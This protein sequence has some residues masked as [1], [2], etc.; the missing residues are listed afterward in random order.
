MRDAYL[1]NYEKYL[2]S[3]EIY[4]KASGIVISRKDEAEEG[5]YSH[6]RRRITIDPDLPPAMEIAVLLHELGHAIDMA[7]IK[8]PKMKV[9][10]NIYYDFDRGTKSSKK[11]SVVLDMEKRAWY[12]GRAIAKM[13]RI[14]LGKWYD[15]TQQSCLYSYRNYR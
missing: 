11:R 7:S 6:T 1:K 15:S 14:R 4:A 2:R 10:D 12:Y 5:S 9:I 13:L 3:I 8:A